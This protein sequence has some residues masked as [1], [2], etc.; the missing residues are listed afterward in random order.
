MTRWSLLS[1]FLLVEL[2]IAAEV[3]V[4]ASSTGPMQVALALWFVLVAPGW[5]VLRLRDLSL[6]IMELAA[7]AVG[8]GVSVYILQTTGVFFLRWWSVPVAITILLAMIVADRVGTAARRGYVYQE[9]E[10]AG[11]AASEGMKLWSLVSPLLLVELIVV[12]EVI[13]FATGA[14][15]L[16]V[17]LGLW[18]I[19]VA[20]GWAVLRMLDLSTD[21][22]EMAATAVG[23][24]VSIDI[25]LALGLFYARVWSID[26]AMT[27][28]LAIILMAIGADLLGTQRAI[29]RRAQAPPV[30]ELTLP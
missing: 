12:A 22:L 26:L 28:L 4:F 8:I 16:R 10:G 9:S 23:I 14:G 15:P 18:V 25:L 5:A 6:G 19:L 1:P 29:A 2:T 3:V 21:S 24:S 11:Q 7:A 17:V 27:I 13:L 30:R 20:P